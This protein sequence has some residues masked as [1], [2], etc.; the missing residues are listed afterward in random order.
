MLR[1]ISR[2]LVLSI[3]AG[4][5]LASASPASEPFGVD[6]GLRWRSTKLEISASLSL[7]KGAPNVQGDAEAA[8]LAA[9]RSWTSAAPLS[10][11][12]K[13]SRL[14]NV[15]PQGV[16]G[17]GVSLITAASSAENL[18]LFP[19]LALS[20]AAATRVFFDRRG[21]ITEADIVLNPYVQFSTNGEFGT[22]DLER[23][24]THELGHLLGLDHS[25]VWGSVML[26]RS[27]KGTGIVPPNGLAEVDM[28]AI[29]GLYGPPKDEIECCSTA[30]GRISGNTIG[31]TAAGL[32][33]VEE[34]DTGRVAAAA[35]PGKN[36]RFRLEGL[37]EGKY[38]IF[39][40]IEDRDRSLTSEE[41]ELAVSLGDEKDLVLTLA[42]RPSTGSPVTFLGSAG[43]LGRLPIVVADRDTRLLI[44]RSEPWP[45]GVSF[46]SSSPLISAI[47]GSE[48]LL[49][50]GPSVKVIGIDIGL[51]PN[52][53]RGEYTLITDEPSGTTRY[54]VGAML[55]P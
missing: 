46:R 28:A 13:V 15:S 5:L 34:S 16:R 44:G 33:W 38:R 39:A 26:E 10:I 9:I 23:T 51:E 29:R 22:Y 12:L 8:L 55:V 20:P 36:G 41:Q 54:L 47:A 6:Q 2:F 32:V 24:L 14:Q 19:R 4:T 31:E 45:V 25:P 43:Q 42:D 52:I 7:L 17:D 18:K 50:F 35:V 48:R 53:P 30:A 27:G 40:Q 37:R 21:A 49:D 3:A 1:T 11:D